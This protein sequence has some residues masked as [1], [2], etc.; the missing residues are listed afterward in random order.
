MGKTLR[1]LALFATMIALTYVG[2]VVVLGRTDYSID[3]NY[4]MAYFDKR[5]AVATLRSPKLVVIGGSSGAFGIDSTMLGEGLHRATY[6]LSL[7]AGV[8]L[9][10]MVHDAEGALSAGDIALV[11]L[12]YSQFETEVLFGEQALGWILASQPN[13]WAELR[14]RNDVLRYNEALGIRLF[15]NTVQFVSARLL[16]RN[17]GAFAGQPVYNRRNFDAHGDFIGHLSDKSGGSPREV[18]A[19]SRVQLVEN[20]AVEAAAI[21]ILNDFSRHATSVGARAVMAY[22]CVPIPWLE[23]NREAFQ[24]LHARLSAAVRAPFVGA[25]ADCALPAT[26][27]Y[28]ST[29]HLNATG[30][31]AWTEMLGRRVGELTRA[32][33]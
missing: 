20:R 4:T 24:A 1:K 5:A 3:N 15:T 19:Q 29:S 31:R 9:K 28:D 10:R 21:T 16:H 26:Q 22:P 2:L 12:D 13:G 14:T 6:N 7:N 17:S 23:R 30:R 8:G 18:A 27:F 25:P 33:R 11:V 32:A